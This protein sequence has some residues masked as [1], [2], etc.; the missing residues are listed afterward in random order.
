MN[1]GRCCRFAI[2]PVTS[3]GHH[4]LFSSNAVCYPVSFNKG[5]S[6]I[7]NHV[8][9][10]IYLGILL[11]PF[12]LSQFRVELVTGLTRNQT[13]AGRPDHLL[14]TRSD[15]FFHNN[16]LTFIVARMV[17]VKEIPDAYQTRYELYWYVATVVQLSVISPIS[18]GGCPLPPSY[19]QR[20]PGSP[21]F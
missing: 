3:E 17:A 8:P 10:A 7:L 12:Q 16:Y 6:E 13:R 11:I 1:I 9:G 5:Q 15:P 2:G 19:G 18:V 14:L 4:Q 20:V 21:L